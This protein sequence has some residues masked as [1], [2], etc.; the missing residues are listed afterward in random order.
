M[1]GRGLLTTTAASPPASAALGLS[2]VSDSSEVGAYAD[3]VR[4]TWYPT[5]VAPDSA[6]AVHR[7]VVRYATLAPSNRNAQ[8]WKMRLHSDALFIHPDFTRRMPLSDPDD[9]QLFIGLGCAAENAGIT[10]RAFGLQGEVTYHPPGLGGM[11]IDLRT[12]AHI[13]P[14]ALFH[15]IPRR[16]SSRGS[17]DGR[18][19][20]AKELEALER[21]GEGLGVHVL[22]VTDRYRIERLVERIHSAN[23]IR[24]MDAARVSELNA[25]TRVNERDALRRRDGLFARCTGARVVPRWLGISLHEFV[26]RAKAD[27]GR[28]TSDLR[29]SGGFAVLIGRE[30]DPR[31]WT[32]VGRACERLL[33]Q[34]TALNMRVAIVNEPI[35]VRATRV[36]LASDLGSPST[37]P[38]VLIRFGY[39]AVGTRS[40]RRPLEQ[41]MV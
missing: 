28:C 25:W 29:S 10:A 11:R 35:E 36:D 15:A 40:L 5:D 20:S 9:E 17:Y 27:N 38:D 6:S 37:L 19:P 13:E 4:E 3:A 32:A 41:V 2:G 26:Q 16:Q 34:A 23:A 22:L 14:S 1:S 31:Q 21:C 12:A 24:A 7:E 18:V 8:P 33:L 30:R 39:G